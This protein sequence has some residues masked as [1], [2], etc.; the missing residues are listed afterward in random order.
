MT[1]TNT[2]ATADKVK[3]ESLFL[4]AVK[5]YFESRVA[6]LGLIVLI[7]I[8]I[9]ALAAP[10]IAPQN[11]YDL[12]TIDIMDGKL[13]PGESSFDGSITYVLGTDT[14]GR[15]MYS[16]IL[17]GLRISLGVGVVST[18]IA[19][20][21]GATIGLWSAYV[22]GKTDAFIMRVVD[23]QLSFPAILVALILLAILGK[24]VDKIILSLV[25]VQWA[26]YARAIRSNVIVERSKEYVEAAKCLAL[27]LRRI[28]FTHVLPNCMPELIVISTVKVA[29][30]IALEATLSFLGLGMPITQPS[31]GLLISNGFKYMQSGYY[32]ISFYPGVALLILIV[33]INLVGD[34]LRDV[35][36]PR[37]KK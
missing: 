34:R 22:G 30:A 35:L 29:G 23:L 26:Y 1:T 10:L 11:P 5:E 12:M 21:M 8:I 27:P 24:G 16:A 18:L 9:V 17:Y 20:V 33:S 28:M 15:D 7:A 2:A 3:E 4:L 13:S 32:W 36:N 31:L 19:L 37:L 25:I 14:Q 6:A